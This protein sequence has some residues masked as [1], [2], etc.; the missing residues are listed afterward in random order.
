MRHSERMRQQYF[1]EESIS[2]QSSNLLSSLPISH[3]RAVQEFI[4]SEAALIILDM[5]RYFLSPKSHA[6]VPSAVSILP[7]IHRLINRFL[8]IQRPVLLTRHINTARNAGMLKDWWNDMIKPADEHSHIIPELMSYNVDVIEKSQYDAFYKTDLEEI[9]RA[10]DIKQIVVT[11]VMTHLC[12]ETTARSAFVRG[13]GVFFPV[14]GTATYNVAFHKATLLNLSHGFA[15]IATVDDILK[16]S[17]SGFVPV[18]L[19][20]SG[21]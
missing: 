19:A 2:E 1:T 7:G 4:A 12:C 17:F 10:R 18:G 3:S 8:E 5:Q 9:L 15:S 11:G 16:E 13:F 20:P 21:V 6:F 14:D